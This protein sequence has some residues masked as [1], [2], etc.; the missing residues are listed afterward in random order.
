MCQRIQNTKYKHRPHSIHPALQCVREYKIQ[1]TNTA[2]TLYTQ[3]YNVSENTKYK[4]Q[5][6]PSLYTPSSTMCQRIQN[7][8]YKDRPHSIHPALQCVRE[9]KI[10]NTKTDL[11]LYT[12]LYNVSENTKYKI[13]S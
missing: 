13:Q 2:L 3:L 8:K 10:Q 9:Y 7:T 12:Q 4:I 6:P 11:T 5:T 1:N